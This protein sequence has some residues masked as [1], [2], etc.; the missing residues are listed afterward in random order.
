MY[1]EL[2]LQTFVKG[3]TIDEHEENNMS[4]SISNVEF[5]WWKQ[6]IENISVNFDSIAAVVSERK[7][8]LWYRWATKQKE[9]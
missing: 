3:G 7:I 9:I 8:E 5:P 2:R 1:V 4:P 6:N